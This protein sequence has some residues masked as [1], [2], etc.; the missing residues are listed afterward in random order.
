MF[1][2]L[3]CTESKESQ[4]SQHICRFAFEFYYN[5]YFIQC[6]AGLEAAFQ[7][8]MP[9]ESGLSLDADI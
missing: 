6:Q 5:N 3:L 2:V 7:V 4:R 9:G 8:P 1:F